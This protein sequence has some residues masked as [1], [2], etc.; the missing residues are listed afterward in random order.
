MPAETGSWRPSPAAPS[1]VQSR[2]VPSWVMAVAAL[3][4]VGVVGFL[5]VVLWIMLGKYINPQNAA[6]RKDLVQSFA[7]VV[8]GL[9]GSLS[10]LAAVGNLYISRRNLQQQR[11]L[12]D[13]R[14]Q[15]DAL[16]DYFDQMSTLL[17]EHDLHS[18][19]EGISGTDISVE[20]SAAR[21]LARAQ[22]LSVLPVLDGHRKFRVIEFLAESVLI[23]SERQ[24]VWLVPT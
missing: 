20:D 13:Q 10:A 18:S 15:D 19:T 7:I 6:E 24:I 9:V 4:L 11:E 2:R 16:R 3:V 17:L 22:T 14:A 12:E 23:S 5:G 21:S 8:A 1:E